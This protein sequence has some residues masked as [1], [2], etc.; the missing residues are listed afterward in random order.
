MCNW[1]SVL[2]CMYT[3]L[4]FPNVPIDARFF[5]FCWLLMYN[6]NLH[7][8]DNFSF[9]VSCMIT[10]I[11]IFKFQRPSLFLGI[12]GWEKFA[13][14]TLFST[15]NSWRALYKN[16]IVTIKHSAKL[17]FK[18]LLNQFNKMT[19]YLKFKRQTLKSSESDD[20]N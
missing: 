8:I 13:F 10:F 18:S 6:Q 5:F 16:C 15:L 4:N 17:Y 14:S 12:N 20:V 3:T 2:C 9:L 7:Y 11:K 19:L 1:I